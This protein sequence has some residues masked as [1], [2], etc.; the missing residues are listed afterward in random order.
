MDPRRWLAVNTDKILASPAAPNVIPPISL[1]IICMANR[2]DMSFRQCLT[3]IYHCPGL[4]TEEVIPVS[5]S[6]KGMNFDQCA[7]IILQAKLIPTIIILH[8]Y[9]L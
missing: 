5:L 3:Y 7:I 9:T 6:N 4:D 1:D 2:A 8:E